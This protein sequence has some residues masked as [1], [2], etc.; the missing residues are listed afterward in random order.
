MNNYNT[1]KLLGKGSYGTVFKIE[2][3]S[4]NKI[5]ALKQMSISK[6]KDKYDENKDTSSLFCPDSILFCDSIKESTDDL[7]RSSLAVKF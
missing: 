7:D 1:L 2:K 4:N 3:K 6:L 5:Y